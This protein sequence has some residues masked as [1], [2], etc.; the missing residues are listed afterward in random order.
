MSHSEAIFSRG[1][2]VQGCCAISLH[3]AAWE[4]LVGEGATVPLCQKRNIIVLLG[5]AFCRIRINA[6]LLQ[7]IQSHTV[8]R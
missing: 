7:F 6:Q 5:M 8:S 3:L 4:E 2:Y 1:P